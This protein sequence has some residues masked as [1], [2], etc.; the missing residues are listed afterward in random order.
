[1]QGYVQ[2]GSGW[3][4]IFLDTF[5]EEQAEN[6]DKFSISGFQNYLKEEGNKFKIEKSFEIHFPEIYSLIKQIYDII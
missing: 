6:I 4:S 5:F 2:K 1:M 3:I